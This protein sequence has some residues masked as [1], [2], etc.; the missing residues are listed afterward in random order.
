MTQPVGPIGRVFLQLVQGG[1]VRGFGLGAGNDGTHRYILHSPYSGPPA[2]PTVA[3]TPV[4][5]GTWSLQDWTDRMR[6]APHSSHHGAHPYSP[7]LRHA[8]LDFTYVKAA[9]LSTHTLPQR[10]QDIQVPALPTFDLRDVRAGSQLEQGFVFLRAPGSSTEADSAPGYVFTR[11]SGGSPV[12]T[13]YWFLI[14]PTIRLTATSSG[15][16]TVPYDGNS[17]VTS[18]PEALAYIQTKTWAHDSVFSV[19]AVNSLVNPDPTTIAL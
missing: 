17:D 7:A 11:R 6:A 3:W 4:S 9:E 14:D 12:S 5:E 19:L 16:E 15:F 10:V 2:G 13:E 1:E 8:A 18:L